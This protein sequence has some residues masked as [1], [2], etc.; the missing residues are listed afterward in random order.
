[1]PIPRSVEPISRRNCANTTALL[2]K[3]QTPDNLFSCTFDD[4]PAAPRGALE[5]SHVSETRVICVAR[6]H[7][8]PSPPALVLQ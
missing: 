1:M 2:T 4:G 8:T 6:T 5:S 3:I 7:P